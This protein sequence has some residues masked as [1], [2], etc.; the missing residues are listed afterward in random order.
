[1][2][3]KNNCLHF[4]F[5]I[6]L[7]HH[8]NSWRCMKKLHIN[9]NNQFQFNDFM[10]SHFRIRLNIN[11]IKT[12]TIEL[13]LCWFSYFC[14]KHVL[15][16]HY[17]TLINP[18]LPNDQSKQIITHTHTHRAIYIGKSI[19]FTFAN[20]HT[21]TYII[22]AGRVT[23]TLDPFDIMFCIMYMLLPITHSYLFIHIAHSP[24]IYMRCW[25]FSILLSNI[26]YS[27]R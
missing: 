10:N 27:R 5:L 6:S 20:I 2:K 21:K 8:V 25:F 3:K 18:E 7:Q 14:I 16:L 22:Y 13:Y 17:V 12:N 9:L 1:M 19:D 26:L 15:T 11:L 4:L 23:S 24:S